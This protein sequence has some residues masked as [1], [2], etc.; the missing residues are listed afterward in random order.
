MARSFP[1][2]P[3]VWTKPDGTLTNEARR[4][5]IDLFTQLGGNQPLDISSLRAIMEA[6]D[7]RLFWV[8]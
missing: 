3:M 5:L 8:L 6:D 4:F 7:K 1:P 2:P